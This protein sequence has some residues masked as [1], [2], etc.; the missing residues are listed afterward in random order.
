MWNNYNGPMLDGGSGSTMMVMAGVG[1][2]PDHANLATS[3][4]SDGV[5]FD[6][7]GDGG[8]TF[9][10]GDANAY[11][12]TTLQADNSGVYAADPNNN[13]RSTTSPYYSL[14][15]GL[16][17][18]AAQLANYPG[19]T[20]T[21]QAGNVGV[22]WHTVVITKATNVVTWLIDGIVI[23]AVP[24]DSTPL[25]TNVFVG[26]EDIFPGAS[27]VPAMSFAVVENFRVET[28]ISAPIIITAINR[29]GANVE[30]LFSGPTEFGTAD[31]KLQSS[32][33]VNGTYLDDNSAT[34]TQLGS[35]SFKATTAASGSAHYYRIRH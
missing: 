6:V 16:T 14:W 23:A 10:V 15:G 32:G 18:P 5:W 31:F 4:A 26:F 9:A 2:T 17:A 29:V 22:S 34:I 35:G 12:A 30:I 20:G 24:A 11:V 33:L 25:G 19:Q 27:G 7:D 13:P 3:G 28:F 1:T 8:S 21:Q